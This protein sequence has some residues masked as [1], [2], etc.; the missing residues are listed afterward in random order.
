MRNALCNSVSYLNYLKGPFSLGNISP[1]SYMS[2][3]VYRRDICLD[4]TTQSSCESRRRQY[5]LVKNAFEVYAYYVLFMLTI[6]DGKCPQ[7]S[8]VLQTKK[9]EHEHVILSALGTNV[10]MV[11][12]NNGTFCILLEK[13]CGSYR[14]VFSYLAIQE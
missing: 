6:S 3:D 12:W 4:H 1:L 8:N 9:C 10:G 13:K 11:Y 14:L 2:N 5:C 7:I